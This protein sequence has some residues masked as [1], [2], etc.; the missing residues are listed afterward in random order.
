MRT[1]RGVW[2]W[3]AA[4]V[5][6]A[7]VLCPAVAIAQSAAI[8]VQAQISTTALSIGQMQDLRFGNV[9]AGL[10]VTI[11]SRTNANAGW[12]EIHGNR[13]AEIQ[14][15]LTLPNQLSTGFWTMPITFSNTAGC[16]R[17]QTAQGGCT[18]YNPAT[19]LVQRIR[20][21]NPPNN[22]FNVWLGGTVS[23]A[24]GQHTGVYLANVRL[25]VAY[26]GN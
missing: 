15:N 24:V 22:T 16:W 11:N 13:N 9:V 10:P 14:V 21:Q 7:A 8:G 12:W 1:R 20:N 5:A 19:T 25:T 23:P 4:A 2:A 3:L 17:K 26:T 18:Q 6:V